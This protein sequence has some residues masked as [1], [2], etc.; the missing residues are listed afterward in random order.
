MANSDNG[1]PFSFKDSFEKLKVSIIGAKTTNIDIKLDKAVSDIASYKSN[2]GRNG[3]ISLV[4]SLIG[5]TAETGINLDNPGGLFG[6]GQTSPATFGQGGRMMRYRTY[7][8]IVSN[9][10]YCF[11]AL[12]VL[13]DNILSPD[14]ITKVSLETSPKTF[15]EDEIK[16]T[17]SQILMVKEAIKQL[18]LEDNLDIIV[19][20]TLKSGDFFAEIAD[21][22]TALTSKALLAE[23]FEEAIKAGNKEVLTY[24]D[25]KFN[26][27]LIMDYSSF[28]EPLKEETAGSPVEFEPTP[29]PGKDKDGRT[30]IGKL[31]LVFHDPLRVIKLQSDLYPLCFGY[32][33][34]PITA[35][36][37]SRLMADQVV[38]SMCSSILKSL[39]KR[40]PQVSELSDDTEL[41]TIISSMIREGDE[42]RAM[43]IRYV[44]P[45]RMQ[46]FMVQSLKYYPYGESIFDSCQFTAKCLIALETALTIQRLSRSTEKRKISVEL[47]LPRDARKMIENLKEEFRKRKVSLDSFGTVDTIPS[48]VTTFEDIYIPTKDGKAFVDVDSFSGGNV[49]IRSKVDELKFL[50]D[51]VVA[52]LGVPPSFINIEEN[53]SNKCLDLLTKIPLLSRRTTNI[54]DLVDEFNKNGMISN[55]YT[56]SYDKKTGKIVPGKIVWAGVTRKNAKVIRVTL[57]NGKSE[58]VTPDHHFML[59]NGEYVEAQYLKQGDSLMPLYTKLSHIKTTK[60]VPYDILYHPGINEWEVTHR[61]V[62]KHEGFVKDGNKSKLKLVAYNKEHGAPMKGRTKETDPEL[63]ERRFNTFKEN[64]KIKGLNHKVLSV[65]VLNYTIDTGDITVEKYHNFA[66]GSGIIVSNSAL[67]EE[68][69]LFARTI[70]AH[71]KYFTNQINELLVKVFDIVNPEIALTMFDNINIALPPPKSLQFERESKYISDLTNLVESLE[72][73]GVPKEY[74]KK[75]FM[76]NIDWSEVENYGIEEDIEKKLGTEKK[77]DEAGGMGDMGGMGGF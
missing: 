72:R 44:P 29:T 47:G 8:A 1:L 3:Y 46:H 21:A 37:P 19:K 53:L 55:K 64:R 27:K 59:R 49:D 20:N 14:D 68:N 50:R 30:P 10:N 5:K 9:I 18:K 43:S 66:V 67:S 34:F 52:S 13:V 56:Y 41:K 31:Q 39:E 11:R 16:E 26:I 70:V 32:L 24:K 28:N 73:I 57:D 76:T 38:N 42:T 62:A 6:Q 35:T 40:I 12:N 61:M 15:L 4:K 63:F 54:K 69:I 17:E 65:E 58:I 7:E 33:I 23:S 51:S 48:M 74:S 60:R 22:Q 25:N 2:S 75:K 71:Q 36:Q 77:D 45:T